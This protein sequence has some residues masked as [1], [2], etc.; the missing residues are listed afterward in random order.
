MKM[1]LANKLVKVKNLLRKGNNL[2]VFLL[3][4]NLILGIHNSI[5]MN[6][7]FIQ[8]RK[9][10]DHRYFNITRTL[11]EIYDVKINTYDGELKLKVKP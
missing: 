6:M 2:I 4:L 3:I 1:F 5:F 8:L 9:K 11:G 7:K 10:V